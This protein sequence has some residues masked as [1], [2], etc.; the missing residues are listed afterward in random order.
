MKI[1]IISGARL[2]FMKIVP[3]FHALEKARNS[4]NNIDYAL[5]HIGQHFD[6]SMSGDFF[7]QLGIPEPNT[8][9]AC[10]GGSQGGADS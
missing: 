6:K 3:I 4:G 8:N 1:T 7:D 10:G 2:N 9:L 5:V